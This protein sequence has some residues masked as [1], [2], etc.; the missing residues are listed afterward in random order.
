MKLYV[1]NLSFKT[2][3]EDLRKLL[4]EYG[5]VESAT[6]VADRYTGQSKGFG[7]V[8]MSSRDEA[9]AAISALNGTQ[10]D[11][12]T[13]RVDEARP[14]PDRGGGDRRGRRDY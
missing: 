10:L 12:C 11:G 4:E 3:E 13:I 1:G 8:E 6:V 14:R 5:T 9:Q 2:S 7:F